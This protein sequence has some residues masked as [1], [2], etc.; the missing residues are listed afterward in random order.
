MAN[1]TDRSTNQKGPSVEN[2]NDRGS[3]WQDFFGDKGG[4][5]LLGIGLFLTLIN[6]VVLFG[7]DVRP[8]TWLFY[9]DMRFWTIHVSIFLWAIAI[10]L[11]AESTENVENYLPI[12][13]VATVICILLVFVFG[14]QTIRPSSQGNQLWFHTIVVATV[15]CAVRS[16]L[17]LYGYWYGEEDALDQEE[18]R[19]FWGLSGF[20]FAVLIIT[21]LMCIIYVKVPV[22]PGMDSLDSD[23]ISLFVSCKN[24]LQTLIR[25]GSGSLAIRAFGFLIFVI[26]IAFVYVAGKWAL[27]FLLRMKGE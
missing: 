8:S 21:G 1:N 4:I 13:R 23:S 3:L 16:L 14:L 27:I 5:P 10:W 20:L 19:W 24:G 11:V 18:S 15:F 12:I 17:L 6:V 22:H 2:T 25:S 9:L 26:S 7:L